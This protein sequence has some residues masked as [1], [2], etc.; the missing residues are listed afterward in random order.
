MVCS[1]YQVLAAFLDITEAYDN[2]LIAILCREL[3]KEG[4]P[5]T[6]RA[7]SVMEHDV[8]KASILFQDVTF[9]RTGYKGL[10]RGFILSPFIYN[11]YTLLILFAPS[12]PY[13]VICG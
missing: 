4:G 1:D 5:N 9:I 12:V 13:F 2:V 11:S 8:G 7:P 3:K 6:A 10:P